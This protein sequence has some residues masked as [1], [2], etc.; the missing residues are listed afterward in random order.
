MNFGQRVRLAW[1]REGRVRE[2]GRERE[3]W[4]A[5]RKRV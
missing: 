5:E 1:V 2:A 3:S 4:R